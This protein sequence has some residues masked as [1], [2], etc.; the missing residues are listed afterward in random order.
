MLMI[1]TYSEVVDIDVNLQLKEMLVVAEA[2]VT[3]FMEFL[4]YSYIAAGQ[5]V[6]M[7]WS[8]ALVEHAN[9]GE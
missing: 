2:V 3:K 7:R 6:A 5:P 9:V 4:E 1:F 8:L